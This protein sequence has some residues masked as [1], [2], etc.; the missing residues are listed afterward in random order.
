MPLVVHAAGMTI[1]PIHTSGLPDSVAAGVRRAA[2]HGELLRL[3]RGSYVSRAEWADASAQER[4]R[5]LVR[6]FVDVQGPAAVVSHRSAVAMHGLPWVGGF[7]DRVVVTDPD[8]DRGQVKPRIQRVGGA[9]RSPDAVLIDGVLVGTLAETGADV[10][11]SDHPWRAVVVLDAVLRR[12]CSKADL[13]AAL[14]ARS[15]RNHRRARTLVDAADGAA[16]SP[17]ESITRWGGIVLG[18]P[19][20][21]LQHEF[22]HQGVFRDR[23]D[24]WYPEHG[25]VVEFDGRQK[26]AVTGRET[27]WDEKRREDRIRRHHEVRGVARVT[28]ADAL[29]AGQLPRLLS[30]AGLPLGRNWASAW[31]L[32]ARR[33]L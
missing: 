23:V 10:A 11:L 12:G 20:P 28:W 18:A 29:P 5:V 25:V 31:R 8:R 9:G 33:A 3:H 24:L 26:Y 2:E 22:R 13:R 4:H 15:S 32:A 17:G 6:S 21:V 19:S 16:E 14:D 30:E 7:G 1:D 27:L